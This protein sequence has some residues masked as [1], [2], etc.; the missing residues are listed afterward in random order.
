MKVA[1]IGTRSASLNI[2]PLILPYVPKET[3]EIISGGAK[4]VDQAAAK[5]A[6]SLSLPF[7]V[8]LPDY[9][10]YGKRAPLVRNLEIIR[11]SDEVLAFW[12]GSSRGTMHCIAECIRCGK[13]IQI[14]RAHVSNHS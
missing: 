12:D 3:T 13:P 14:G 2:A 4:G 9:S 7:H 1:I 5:I 6:E 8:F 10:R 11:D